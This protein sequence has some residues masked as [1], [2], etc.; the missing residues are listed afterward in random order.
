MRRGCDGLVS[1][2]R[3]CDR[4]AHLSALLCVPPVAQT[5]LPPSALLSAAHPS[6]RLSQTLQ[7]LLDGHSLP[8][9]LLAPARRL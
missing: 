1:P 3:C 2:S 4:S 8:S 9:S 6:N 7:L 5:H